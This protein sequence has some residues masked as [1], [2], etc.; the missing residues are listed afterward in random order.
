MSINT[1][2]M[3][4]KSPTRNRLKMLNQQH[5]TSIPSFC[6]L[7]KFSGSVWIAGRN[8]YATRVALSSSRLSFPARC[9]A[10]TF[11]FPSCSIFSDAIFSF[12]E[13]AMAIKACSLVLGVYLVMFRTLCYI[14]QICIATCAHPRKVEIKPIRTRSCFHAGGFPSLE[15]GVSSSGNRRDAPELES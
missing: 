2:M 10:L 9:G 12:A 3:G 13:S 15:R 7:L 4:P 5:E 11:A 1:G 8:W 6:H 14:P